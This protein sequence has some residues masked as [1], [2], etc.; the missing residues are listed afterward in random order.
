MVFFT[1]IVQV[2]KKLLSGQVLAGADDFGHAR[3]MH[4]NRMHLVALA[5]KMKLNGV[6]GDSRMAV[7]HRGQAVSMIVARGFLVAHADEADFQ[8]PHDRGQDFFAA[9]TFAREILGEAAANGRQHARKIHQ[10][11]KL[12]LVANLPPAMMINVLLA[13]SLVAA[14]RLQ[15]AVRQRTNPDLLP[16][17]WNHQRPD[18]LKRL[19][20]TH[21]P[22]IRAAIAESPANPLA[23]DAGVVIMHVTQPHFARRFD[24]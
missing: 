4:C 12:G 21:D 2:M 13:V 10:P 17:R 1:R 9:K 11:V 5:A 23:A 18:A 14:A 15:V 7:F 20:V 6:A 24:R 19:P 8:Q 16:G 22:A 3:I